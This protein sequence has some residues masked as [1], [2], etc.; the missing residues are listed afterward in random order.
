MK[1]D[2]FLRVKPL[3]AY[4]KEGKHKNIIY[5]L[6]PLK[7]YS[8]GVHGCCAGLNKNGSHRHIRSVA[9]RSYGLVAAGVALLKKCVTTG[10][11]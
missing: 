10:G 1:K 9:I 2:T 5:D 8:A 11:F 4:T 3:K 6:K 7:S